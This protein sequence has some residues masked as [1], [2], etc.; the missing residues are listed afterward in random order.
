MK[1]L[2]LLSLFAFA[3]N[4]SADEDLTINIITAQTS[5]LNAIITMENEKTCD[6][7]GLALSCTKAQA[8]VA[9]GAVGG[10][11]CTD[12]QARAVGA[13]IY[14]ITN[15][16]RSDFVKFKYAG[17]AFTASK[18]ELS[19]WNQIKYCR[20][21]YPGQNQTARDAACTAKGLSAGCELCPN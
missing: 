5:N 9:Y 16:G 10:A 3:T 7:R 11:S 6:S 20:F 13:M 4:L 14:P 21:T 19:A 2:L 12:A 8:C 15:G 18:A 17:V 1:K